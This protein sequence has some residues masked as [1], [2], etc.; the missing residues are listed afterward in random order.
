MTEDR[1]P[2]CAINFRIS[3]VCR[4]GHL[5]VRPRGFERDYIT[6]HSIAKRD[7]SERTVII[8]QNGRILLYQPIT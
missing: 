8:Y 3:R 4:R 6:F 2:Q 7:Y 5:K 1:S